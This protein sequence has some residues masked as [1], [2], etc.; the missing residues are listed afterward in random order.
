MS[1]E[2]ASVSIQAE[3]IKKLLHCE[4]VIGL[5][6]TPGLWV[7]GVIGLQKQKEVAELSLLEETHE[8]RVEGLGT[9]GRHLN[10]DRKRNILNS[11][12]ELVNQSEKN[13]RCRVLGHK[14]K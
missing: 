2:R 3:V 6:K 1:S 7:L 5:A 13:R 14:Y 11:G 10:Q 8:G 9:S 12:G 4:L